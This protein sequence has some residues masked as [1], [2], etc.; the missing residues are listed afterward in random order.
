MDVV[1][2]DDLAASPVFDEVLDTIR[3]A[4]RKGSSPQK[5]QITPAGVATWAE[6]GERCLRIQHYFR[7]MQKEEDLVFEL[8]RDTPVQYS[9]Q[10]VKDM[11]EVELKASKS[12]GSQPADN[13]TAGPEE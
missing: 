10:K 5:L 13:V 11:M 8:L 6:I 12:Q 9:W 7:E 2:A 4:M 3:E 1:T